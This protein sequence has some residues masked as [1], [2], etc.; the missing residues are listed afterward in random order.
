MCAVVSKDEK[1]PKTD[2][3]C[4]YWGIASI[5]EKLPYF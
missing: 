1:Q 4:L 3:F 5:L 2:S